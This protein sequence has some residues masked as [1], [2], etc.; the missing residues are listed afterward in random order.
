[1]RRGNPLEMKIFFAARS[2]YHFAYYE[3]I[4]E[5]LCARG[6]EV[7]YG[8]DAFWNGKG[9][10]RQ[11]FEA[12]ERAHTTGFS[13]FPLAV[14][15]Y[16][17]RWLTHAHRYLASLANYYMHPEQSEF[18]HERWAKKLPE[19]V[20]PFAEWR[21]IRW[22]L[23]LLHVLRVFSL[24]ERLI[25]PPAPAVRQIEAAQPDIV[26]VSPGNMRFG[27]EIDYIKAARKLGIPSAI[28]VLSW[29]NLSTKGLICAEPD[30]VFCWNEMHRR[31]ARAFHDI[32]DGKLRITGAPFFEKWWGAGETNNTPALPPDC[33]LDPQKPVLT[34]LG[35]SKRITPDELWLV[36]EIY[37]GLQ[38]LGVQLLVRPHPTDYER[39]SDMDAREGLYVW[40]PHDSPP[41]TAAAQAEMR[42]AF[43]A[44]IGVIGINTSAFLDAI[45]LDVPCII[46]MTDAYRNTQE[47]ALHFQALKTDMATIKISDAD[48]LPAVLA[49][50]AAGVDATAAARKEFVEKFV[51]A[52][53]RETPP[54]ALIAHHLE[55]LA[56]RNRASVDA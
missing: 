47:E 45:V 37:E 6:H 7:A 43:A 54:G 40:M 10:G 30:L 3:T 39:F 48:E 29:D 8:F 19:A 26:V 44:S 33:G 23:M 21:I 38:P 34:Y 53:G 16:D 56:G 5:A 14:D 22:S 31:E 35:S 24:L 55:K 4:L 15:G 1:M 27:N 9:G 49:D 46:Y 12:F 17:A 25:P 28:P 18:Y 36:E 41:E 42:R 20:R 51:F 11:A 13:S 2:K 52:G 32:P 50:L